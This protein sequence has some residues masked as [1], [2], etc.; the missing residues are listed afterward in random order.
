[1]TRPKGLS[2]DKPKSCDQTENGLA[3]IN[4]ENNVSTRSE[5]RW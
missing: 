3:K 2:K 4:Q 1:V 5:I